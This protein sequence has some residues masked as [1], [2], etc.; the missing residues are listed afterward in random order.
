MSNKEKDLEIIIKAKDKEISELKEIISL[1][2]QK[3][4]NLETLLKGEA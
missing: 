3:I 2:Q 4:I 1:Q